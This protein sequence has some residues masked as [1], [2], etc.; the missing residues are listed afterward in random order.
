MNIYDFFGSLFGLIVAVIGIIICY[1]IG[2]YGKDTQ[3]GFWGSFLLCFLI[4]PLIVFIILFVI[5]NNKRA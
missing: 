4:S 3:L 2:K 5:K 1:A